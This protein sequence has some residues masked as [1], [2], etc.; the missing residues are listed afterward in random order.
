VEYN[1]AKDGIAIIAKRIVGTTV[2]IISNV[3]FSNLDLPKNKR[4]KDTSFILL[5][6]FSEPSITLQ[7]K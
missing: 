5:L 1:K 6:L 7:I 4:S 3:E 2:H